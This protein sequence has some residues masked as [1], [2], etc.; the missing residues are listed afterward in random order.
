LVSSS[1]GKGEK[2]MRDSQ[3]GNCGMDKQLHGNI[4]DD[5]WREHEASCYQHGQQDYNETFYPM[6]AA[7]SI[8]C[9]RNLHYKDDET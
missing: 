8:L 6:L 7:D 2:V 3:D 5:N 4:N 1:K 9:V